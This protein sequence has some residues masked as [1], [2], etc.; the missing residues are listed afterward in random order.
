LGIVELVAGLVVTGDNLWLEYELL[1]NPALFFG[2]DFTAETVSFLHAFDTLLVEADTNI[3]GLMSGRGSHT[4]WE[5][6]SGVGREHL[7]LLGC[8]FLELEL[9]HLLLLRQP[10]LLKVLLI[11]SQMYAL[12]LSCLWSSLHG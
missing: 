4:G 1:F 8:P 7:A 5:A 12:L 2:L 11:Q 6:L 3:K 10:G 9:F